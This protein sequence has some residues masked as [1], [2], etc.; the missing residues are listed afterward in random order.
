VTQNTA[1]A[2]DHGAYA[3]EID[4][5]WVGFVGPG[6]AAKGLDGSGAAEGPSSA[7]PNSGQGTIPAAGTRGTWTDETDIRP[8]LI[9]LTGLADDYEHDGRVVTEI[10]ARGHGQLQSPQVTALGACYKQL[11]SSVGE[12]GTA[13]LQ[14]D[15]AAIES[16]STNDT[17]YISTVSRLAALESRRDGLAQQIKDGLEGLAF[18][19]EAIHNPRG[20]TQSCTAVVEQAEALAG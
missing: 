14:A 11:N 3:P 9:Y 16:S 5:T 19:G 18:G 17:T 15:T 12:F 7:G 4:T 13:T 20:L 6:V 1:F 8:T 10:L 2:W